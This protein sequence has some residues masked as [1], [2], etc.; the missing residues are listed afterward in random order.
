MNDYC[1]SNLIDDPRNHSLIEAIKSYANKVQRQVYILDKPLTDSKYSYDFKDGL[2]ILEASKKICFVNLGRNDAAFDEYFEDVLSDIYSISDN[3]SCKDTIGRFR[4][5]NEIVQKTVLTDIDNIESFMETLSITDSKLR[6]KQEILL[7]LFIGSINDMDKIGG[8]NVPES[9]LDK[10]KHKI[11]LFDT[12][13][14]RFIYQEL[15]SKEKRISIQGMSGT[16]KTELLLHKC[17]ELYVNDPD[18]KIGFTCYNRVLSVELAQR[19][20]DFFDKMKANKQINPKRLMIARAWGGSGDELSGIYRYI[21]SFYNIPFYSY[22]ECLNFEEACKM[23]I[24]EIKEL[25]EKDEKYKQKYAYTYLFVDESQDFA[26]AFFDLCELVTEKNVFIAGDI[27]QSIFEVRSLSSMQP[28]FLLS[29]CYRTDPKTFMFAHALG[30]GLF[31]KQK[32]HWLQKNEWELCGYQ[33]NEI[34]NGSSQM[35]SL[36]REPIRRFEDIDANYESLRLIKVSSYKDYIIQEISRLKTEYPTLCPDDIAIIYIDTQG[37]SYIYN[38]APLL[39]MNIQKRLEWDANLAYETKDKRPNEVFISNRNNV[40]GLEFPFVFCISRGITRQ[41]KYRNVLYTVL[42]RS[43]LRSYLI[44]PQN[45]SCGLTESM[46]EGGKEIMTK[47]K[48]TVVVPTEEEQR[49]MD[50]WQLNVEQVKS[51]QDRLE[52]I[53]KEKNIVNSEL[54]G[55]VNES[56]APLLSVDTTDEDLSSL[57]DLILKNKK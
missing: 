7:S 27:F 26:A 19:I 30:L 39:K 12:Q 5:W 41:A 35:V 9:V 13:Q 24:K 49:E 57:I 16:G 56:I 34:N 11:L 54:K 14:T 10:V 43:F 20:P 48:M 32:L 6:R 51:L 29:N 52:E 28:N 55:Q 42:T 31:E 4:T 18:C 40:K 1:F 38:E 3:Y 53:F 22:R 50:N 8:L 23:A 47:H 44:L 15:S 2:I 25:R 21:C 17:K 36:T 45:E 37:E 46:I 33:V